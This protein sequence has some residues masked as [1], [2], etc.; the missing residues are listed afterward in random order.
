[1]DLFELHKDELVSLLE[2]EELRFATLQDTYD[3][4][5]T[6][7]NLGSQWKRSGLNF[8]ERIGLFMAIECFSRIAMRGFQ[9]AESLDRTWKKFCEYAAWHMQTQ[10]N[11]VTSSDVRLSDCEIHLLCSLLILKPSPETISSGNV[12][13]HWCA[14]NTSV[15]PITELIKIAEESNANATAMTSD[16]AERLKTSVAML[17]LENIAASID[18]MLKLGLTVDSN[19]ILYHNAVEHEPEGYEL[20]VKDLSVLYQRLFTFLCTKAVARID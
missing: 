15:R 19:C 16:T 12:A 11:S 4:T 7:L 5:F 1:M 8:F 10:T 17:V 20:A 9:T 14:A 13:A 18:L 6:L 2:N 3:F